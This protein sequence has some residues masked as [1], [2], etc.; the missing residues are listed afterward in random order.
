MRA[1]IQLRRRS[2]TLIE[3]LV[4]IA[5][6]VILAAILIPAVGAAQA[7][8]LE[9]DCASNLRQL[10]AALHNYAVSNRGLFP[11]GATTRLPVA[12]VNT[13]PPPHTNFI[14][15]N[16]VWLLAAMDD[17]VPSNS[18]VWFCKRHL[19]AEGLQL[20]SEQA[21]G[22]ISYLFWAF[23]HGYEDWLA[24][25]PNW[26][27]W[28][29]V[30]VPIGPTTAW[31]PVLYTNSPWFRAGWSTNFSNWILL[32]DSFQSNRQYH[33]GQSTVTKPGDVGTLVLLLDSSVAKV[34][35]TGGMPYL[36][37]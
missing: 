21:A 32:S 18:P 37:R 27:S 12:P 31:V 30:Y 8:A 14:S 23:Y 33:A 26:A 13:S 9:A 35:P 36:K 10:G 2:F 6:I 5:I 16:Q 28:K 19:K 24:G 20:E 25:A 11:G 29:S 34:S 4:V 22:R 15:S 7:R 1:R 3:M 17:Y